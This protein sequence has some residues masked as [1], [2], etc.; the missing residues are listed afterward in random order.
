MEKPSK[1]F[2]YIFEKDYNPSYTN[3]AYGGITPKGEI[4][5]NFFLERMPIPY[6][7]VHEFNKDG[8]LGNVI[9]VFPEADDPEQ[10]MFVR[11]ISSGV[12]MNLTVAKEIHSWLSECIKNVESSTGDENDD[13]DCNEE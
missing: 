13:G 10:R 6:D 5:M 7:V 1:K 9:K 4:I 12:I 11:Y 2:K 3:G 8:T